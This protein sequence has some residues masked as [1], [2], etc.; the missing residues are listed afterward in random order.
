[1][2]AWHQVVVSAHAV[3]KSGDT[4]D[5][6]DTGAVDSLDGGSG[7]LGL[8][9]HDETGGSFLVIILLSLDSLNGSEAR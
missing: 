1:M 2:S 8:L 4:V 5:V 6:M 9:G 7:T 3:V